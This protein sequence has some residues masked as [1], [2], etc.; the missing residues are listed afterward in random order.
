[1]KRKHRPRVDIDSPMDPLEP[2]PVSTHREMSYQPPQSRRRRKGN[3]TGDSND[4]P[5]K[6]RGLPKDSPEVRTSKTLSWILRHGAKSEGITMRPD[7]YVEVRDLLNNNR[8]RDLNFLALEKTVKDDPKNRYS[9]ICEADVW[10]IRANQGHSIQAVQMELEPITSAKQIPM[11]VHGTTRNAWESISTQ[12]LSKMTRN[13]IHLAQGIA[14]QS[15]VSGM[16]SS[17]QV[18]IYID[19]Q[20]ALDAG[21]KFGVSTNGVVLSEGDERGFIPPE[22]FSRVENTD[23]SALPG[24]EGAVGEAREALVI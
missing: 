9:L 4:A 2:S 20:K 24:W 14:G 22:Y 3:L 5:G 15:V 1:L 7:G 16:R 8:L 12:G 13:H 10:L 21:L 18:L 19:I 11:A 23:G 17:S 6:K